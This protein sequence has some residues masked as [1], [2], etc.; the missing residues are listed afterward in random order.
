[1]KCLFCHNICHKLNELD[2]SDNYRCNNHAGY[3]VVYFLDNEGYSFSNG[4]Y[5]MQ[6]FTKEEKF[7]LYHNFHTKML[8]LDCIPFFRPEEADN[9]IKTLVVFS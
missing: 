2:V 1:M 9:K 5:I 8:Y 3:E 6:F 4:E 7:Y